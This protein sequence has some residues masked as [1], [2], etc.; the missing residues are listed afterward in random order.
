MSK[1]S[2]PPYVHGPL[3]KY[4]SCMH[5]ADIYRNRTHFQPLIRTINVARIQME[6]LKENSLDMFLKNGTKSNQLDGR[7]PFLS[8]ELWQQWPE[9]GAPESSL[10]KTTS[11]F[12]L[13]PQQAH[14]EAL[15]C[16]P[17]EAGSPPEGAADMSKKT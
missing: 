8:P 7:S 14:L 6:L 4:V 9:H 13:P 11:G 16:L 12:W 5:Q 10:T 3:P 2:A 17:R 1:S 15:P